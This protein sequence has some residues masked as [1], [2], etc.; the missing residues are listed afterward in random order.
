MGSGFRVR[1]QRFHKQAGRAIVAALLVSASIVA[2]AQ[3]PE[4]GYQIFQGLRTLFTVQYPSK[5]WQVVPGGSAS[6]V[7]FTQKK[8]EATVVIEYQA[9]TLELAPTEIDEGFAQI[10]AEPIAQHQPT[11]TDVASHI[12]EADGRKVIVIDYNRKGIAGA[13]KVRQYSLPIGKQMYRIVCSAPAAL[14][15]KYEPTFVTVVKTFA[16]AGG[17]P[18]A[19]AKSE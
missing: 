15:A 14:F 9:L 19:P 10:E 3:T 5:D 2:S 4:K 6:L 8:A 1:R 13:E 16:V 18:A 11:A 12:A 7:A 17:A